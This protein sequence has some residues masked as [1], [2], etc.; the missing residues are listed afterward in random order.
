MTLTNA[1]ACARSGRDLL[2]GERGSAS[3]EFAVTSVVLFMTLLGLMKMCL[4]IYTYHYISEAA[5]EG[6]RYAMVRGTSCTGCEVTTDQISAYVKN[7]GYPGISSSAMTVTTTR[8]PFP[9]TK[10]CT[11]SVACNNPGDLVTITVQYAFPL[12]I[13]FMAAR[14]L[15]MQSR[16]AMVI[17]Q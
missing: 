8:G 5:R 3:V 12:S 7:L 6:T 1:N 14:T 15:N 13:P 4:G 17:S 16:S 2:R 11:P 10:T 9:S